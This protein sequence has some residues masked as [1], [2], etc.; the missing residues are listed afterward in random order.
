MIKIL[1]QAPPYL[2]S[3]LKRKLINH[4]L[5]QSTIKSRRKMLIKH[6]PTLLS[7]KLAE[8]PLKINYLYQTL[9]TMN[10]SERTKDLHPCHPEVS[11][12]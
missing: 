5:E 8:V 6:K 2:I 3:N 1:L 4:V 11:R 9:E 12:W 10:N 7:T